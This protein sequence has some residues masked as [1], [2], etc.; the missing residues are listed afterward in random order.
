MQSTPSELLMIVEVQRKIG[1]QFELFQRFV[2]SEQQFG[3]HYT[4]VIP[5]GEGSAVENSYRW[6]NGW[7]TEVSIGVS[8]GEPSGTMHT[9]DPDRV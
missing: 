8:T 3:I 7:I 9:I 2:S 5:E 6:I 4:P 1:M